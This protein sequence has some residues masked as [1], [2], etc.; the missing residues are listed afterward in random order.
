[1]DLFARCYNYIRAKVARESGYYPYFK[2]VES[3]QDAEVTID[4]KKLIM[5]GSNNYLGLTSHPKLKEAAQKAIQKYGSGCTGSRFLNGTLD[6]HLELEEKLAKFLNKEAAL[7][8]TTGYQTNLGTIS[9][10]VGRRDMVFI[11]RDDHASIVDGCRL[12][13]GKV[14]KFKHNDVEDLARLLESSPDNQGKLVIVEGVYSVGGDIAELPDMTKTCQRYG[15]RIMVDDAHGIGILGKN[16]RGT[17]EHFGL[18]N[19]VDLV[20]ITFSKSL[21]SIGGMIA[22]EERV[23]DFIKHHG[24]SLI[25]SASMPPASVAAVLAA[26]DVIENEPERRENLLH[27]AKIMRNELKNLGFVVADGLTPI[28]PVT[29]GDLE[30]TFFIWNILFEGGVYVNPMIAPAVPPEQ[31]LLRV[32]L[33]ATHKP[34]HLEKALTVFEKAGKAAGI[35]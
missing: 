11:D 10:L 35:I 5:L 2:A 21:A 3:E 12:S 8:F 15:A 34:E 32:S 9:S 29:I 7:V 14:I 13:Y 17:L 23:L 1:M 18:N 27:N 20:M 19:E 30:K 26:L 25:F 22:G 4:G 16:G 24:R 28:I 6:I 31:S 33:V